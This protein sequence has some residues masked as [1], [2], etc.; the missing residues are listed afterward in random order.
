LES[1]TE[2]GVK[3]VIDWANQ[4]DGL[5]DDDIFIIADV[6]EVMSREALHRLQWCGMAAD[7]ISGS[8]WVPMG[9]L[10]LAL[11]PYFPVKD[12]P[13]RFAMPTIYGWKS[14]SSKQ[15]DGK[16]LFNVG[17]TGKFVTGGL[18]MTNP[19]FLPTALLKELTA[20]EDDFYSGFINT[21]YLMSMSE[22]SFAEEQD[23]LYNLE[24]QQCFREMSDKVEIAKDVD[25]KL[26][27]FLE[28]NKVSSKWDKSS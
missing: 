3:T 19:A 14:I 21:D 4:T 1:Q 13:H 25:Q 23:R 5:Q 16:R 7:V 9:N 22:E 10:N 8:L 6:D 20:T 2:T 12:N 17:S 15:F 28:C 27:W 26:P 24:Y 11:K 18:H